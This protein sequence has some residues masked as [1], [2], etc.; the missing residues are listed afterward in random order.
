MRPK[1]AGKTLRKEWIATEYVR[2][3]RICHRRTGRIECGEGV[4]KVPNQNITSAPERALSPTLL[5]DEFDRW[6]GGG[7]KGDP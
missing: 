5:G 4:G 2:R 1:S 7:R 3:R 6:L